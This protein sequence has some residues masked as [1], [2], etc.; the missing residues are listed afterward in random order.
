[1]SVK[2]LLFCAVHSFACWDWLWLFLISS[3]QWFCDHKPDFYVQK[4]KQCTSWM[5]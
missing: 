1:L 2:L 4:Q 5:R 3:K